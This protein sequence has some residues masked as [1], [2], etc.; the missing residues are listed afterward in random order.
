MS[1]F[2]Y[3]RVSTFKQ[4]PYRYKL[5][6]IDKLETLPNTDANNAL[7]LGSAMHTGI[8]KTVKDALAQYYA[9]YPIIDDLQINEAMK[10]QHLIPLVKEV[11]PAGQYEVK[12]TDDDFIG[13]IDLLVHKGNNHFDQYEFKYSKNVDSYLK[14][15]QLHIYKHFYEKTCPGH[16]IDNLYYVFIPKTQ[17]RQKK[18]EDLYQFRKRLQSELD[19]MKIM[20][21]KVDYD[22]QKVKDYLD[23]VKEIKTASEYPKN[24]TKLCPWCQYEPYCKQGDT[25]MLLPKNERRTLGT[26]TK[27]V[28]WLYGAPFS[29]KTYLTD[30][31]ADPL[32]LNTDGNIRN[33]TAP[34]LPIKDVVTTTGNVVK[35][36]LAW[37]IFK[38]AIEELEKKQND[39]KTIVV[40]L[41]E[42]TLEHCR[43]AMYEELD[44]T[45]ES[46]AGF[47]KGYD[48]IRKEFLDTIKRLTNL[49][50]ENIILISHE[51][52]SKAINKR[53]GSSLTTIRPNI[54]EKLASKIAGMVDIVGR[55]VANGDDRKLSFKAD[56]H[57]FGGGRLA[58]IKGKEIPLT[59]EALM[60]VYTIQDTPAPAPV[61]QTEQA[62]VKQTETPTRRRVVETP[63]TK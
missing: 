26:N 24:C 44:I 41:L 6:Y 21:V 13:F 47:G 54:Q 42:D 7:Y 11:I 32:M 48:I 34:V 18:T 46:D 16:K 43:T 3:S 63:A 55:V 20:V 36:K 57:I 40:D 2:S 27:K 8:E 12:V 62:P 58:N 23:G 45:H 61:Q 1:K 38:E 15:A 30:K 59:Y 31:F 56:E 52:S 29:G 60:Q 37:T 4:C 19:K 39:F 33:V 17:I 28:I 51:D 9:N 50:Y 53:D 25:T 14:S 5:Q 22:F 35:R 49:D 10:L